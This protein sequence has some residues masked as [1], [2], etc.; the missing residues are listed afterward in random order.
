MVDKTKFA[1]FGPNITIYEPTTFAQTNN[2]YLKGNSIIAEYCWILGGLGLHIGNF[3]HIASH[4]SLAGGGIT[5]IEDFCSLSAGVRFV[6]GTDLADGSGLVNSTIPP[7]YRG[8]ER[9]FIHLKKH[10]FVATNVIVFPGVTIGEGA[11]V[12]AGSIV[13]KDVEPWTIN[14][15]YPLKPIKR[16]PKEE[17]LR[18]G[19]LLYQ[20]KQIT[21]FEPSLD[22]LSLKKF[23]K[24]LPS[25]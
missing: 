13:T 12:G 22:L 15:G 5:I 25:R 21:P 3:I 16:R 8:V 7:A 11:V 4:V 9:G 6:S 1:E 19:S 10:S 20:D 14:I 17:I 23:E 24:F 18:L 2:I